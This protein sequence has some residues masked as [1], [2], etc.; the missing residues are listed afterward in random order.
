MM[1]RSH[2]KVGACV[3]AVAGSANLLPLNSPGVLVAVAGLVLAGS[4]APDLDHLSSSVTRSWG[5]LTW[6]LSHIVRWFCRRIYQATRLP[7][8][9][10]KKDPHRTF[11]HTLPGAMTAGAIVGLLVQWDRWAA[12]VVL[13]MLF[14]T[15]A[16][17]VKKAYL[18]YGAIAGGAVAYGVYDALATAW[19]A[20]GIALA[21]GCMIHVYSDCVT[22]GGAPLSFPRATLKKEIQQDGT[23]RVLQRRRWH[24]SGP[25]EWIRFYT[26]SA[27]ETWVLRGT[28]V[29]TA[30]T[31]YVLL[32]GPL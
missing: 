10:A 27:V 3:V 16:R 12:V 18:G 4:V 28:M 19:W 17:C 5:W 26:G 32:G 1:A 22:K 23:T 7:N 15:A 14:G 24:M 31:C 21:M 20:L 2:I 9:P 11:T 8:D 6:L 25:P 29:G 13:A 30:F